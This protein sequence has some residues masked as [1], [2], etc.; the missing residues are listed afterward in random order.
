MA[1]GGLEASGQGVREMSS[2]R[3]RAV[4]AVA[5]GTAAVFALGMSVGLVSIV[6]EPAWSPGGH[7]QPQFVMPDGS[8]VYGRAHALSAVRDGHGLSSAKVLSVLRKDDS[9]PSQSSQE[10]RWHAPLRERRPDPWGWAAVVAVSG[11]ASASAELPSRLLHDGWPSS[12]SG[13]SHWAAYMLS[14]A[15]WVSGGVLVPPGVLVAAT[16]S[17]SAVPMGP[18][19][20]DAK[21]EAARRAGFD[22]V[23]VLDPYASPASAEIGSMRVTYLDDPADVPAAACDMWPDPESAGRCRAAAAAFDR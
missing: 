14:W 7:Y 23:I 21:T 4:R 6:R 15:D 8:V 11:A 10:M 16:G 19:L 13:P 22:L 5:W 17:P 2:P 18:G 12:R 9:F 3:R 20:V 1:S